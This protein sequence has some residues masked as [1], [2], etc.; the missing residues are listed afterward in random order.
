MKIRAAISKH[1]PVSAP[2]AQGRPLPVPDRDGAIRQ[3]VLFDAEE[4]ASGR[5]NKH[6]SVTK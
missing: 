5:S 6:A 4:L 3:I 1:S 2:F